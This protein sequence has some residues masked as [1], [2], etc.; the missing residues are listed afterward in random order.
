VIRLEWT[1]TGKSALERHLGGN[2]ISHL[3]NADLN[4]FLKRNIRL[5]RV[6]DVAVGNLF[7][8]IKNSARRRRSSQATGASPR[9]PWRHPNYRSRYAAWVL[10]LA[11]A[12]RH[13]QRLGDPDLALRLSRNSAPLLRGYFRQLRDGDHPRRCGPPKKPRRT[14]TPITDYRINACFKRVELIPVP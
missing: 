2:Q 3:Q 14:R 13:E 7:R 6:D 5:E 9:E 8:G 10:S 1:L 12:S 11:L 4:D